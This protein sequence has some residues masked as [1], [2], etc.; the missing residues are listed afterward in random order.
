MKRVCVRTLSL[1][2]ALLM[3]SSLLV[4][5]SSAAGDYSL[6]E[7]EIQE[8]E[9]DW[10]DHGWVLKQGFWANYSDTG[11]QAIQGV[12]KLFCY[13]GYIVSIDS[14]YGNQMTTTAIRF[15]QDK[16]LEDNGIIGRDTFGALIKAARE[17]LSNSPVRDLK[18]SAPTQVTLSPGETTYVTIN[19][20]G[21]GIDS[22]GGTLSGSGMSAWFAG[23]EW[24]AYP[25]NCVAKLKITAD[26]SFQSGS[27]T[28][29]LVNRGLGVIL[30][31]QIKIVAPNTAY[32]A[33]DALAYAKTYVY[34]NPEQWCAEYVSRALRAGGLDIG[35]EKGVKGLYYALEKSNAGRWVELKIESDGRIDPSKNVGLIS[36]GDPIVLYCDAC[37][38]Y[39]GKPWVHAVLVSDIGGSYVKV[40]AHNKAKN[41]ETYYNSC[42]IHGSSHTHAFAYHIG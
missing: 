26:D 37:V 30:T 12:Q 1:V 24:V 27:I 13:I 14:S 15:Q 38:S 33:E 3:L 39:D 2:L 5:N 17:K 10:N 34:L 11:R 18:I 20:S 4:V 35:I 16:G 40:Y 21:V 8:I 41:N 29:K 19:F 22:V 9:Q 25:G 31:Q 32:R 6:T 7:T 28:F 42:Y 23:I 36:P